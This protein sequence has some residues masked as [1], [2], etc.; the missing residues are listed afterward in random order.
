M[1]DV[2]ADSALGRGTQHTRHRSPER[3]K[4]QDGIGRVEAEARG[5]IR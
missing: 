3:V 1:F 4:M 5:W 2:I